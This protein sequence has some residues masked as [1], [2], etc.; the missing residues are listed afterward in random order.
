[1][2]VIILAAG[3]SI[4][5]GGTIKCLIKNPFTGKTCLQHILD[6][7]CDCSPTIVVGYRAVEIM[8]EYPDV[9]YTYNP[10]WS[11]TGP[12][13]SVGLA[14]GNEPCYIV[15]GDIII[16]R[17]LVEY[18]N[19]APAN[20]VLTR[21][22]ENRDASVSNFVIENDTIREAYA[23]HV[24]NANDSVG[25]GIFKISD[26]EL[27]RGMKENCLTHNNLHIGMNINY[28]MP[29]IPVHNV[30]IGNHSFVEFNTYFDYLNFLKSDKELFQ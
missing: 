30:D 11:V 20:C 24:R 1:M 28:N 9:E 13:Y 23:G 8:Q 29:D 17:V 3:N 5:M 12:S 21:R 6:A 16:E 14:V 10:D 19:K 26:T 15:P 27:L 2:Q 22:L 18:L 4:Q 7:F 25:T